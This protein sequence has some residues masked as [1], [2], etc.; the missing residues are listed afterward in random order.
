MRRFRSGK[1]LEFQDWADSFANRIH[2]VVA[3]AVKWSQDPDENLDG[4]R[5]AV[6]AMGTLVENLEG[7]IDQ[8][9]WRGALAVS[10]LQDEAN[11]Q[12]REE[13][14]KEVTE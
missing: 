2:H 9:E 5:F 12:L 8:I 4:M 6:K 1:H 13:F 3:M 11:V 10:S 7:L 14:E